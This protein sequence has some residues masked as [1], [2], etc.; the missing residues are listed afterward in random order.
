[1]IRQRHLH[2]DQQG[3]EDGFEV[4][5]LYVRPLNRAALPLKELKG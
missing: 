3:R 4:A 5:Q 2:A 1:V